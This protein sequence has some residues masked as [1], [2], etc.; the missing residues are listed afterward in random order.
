DV[1]AETIVALARRMASN[2]TMI[3]ASW[4]LQRA[5]HGEQP[6]W[7]TVAL[8]AMLGQIGL[9]GGGFALGHG[10]VNAAGA[11]AHAF[12]GPVLPQGINADKTPIPVARIADMP[13]DPGGE[14]QFAGQACTLPDIRLIY[15]CGGNPFHHHQDLNR[16]IAAWRKPETIVIHEQFWTAAA[17]HADIVLP[18]TTSLERDDIGS[19]GRDRFM[20]AMKKAVDAPGE[21]RDDYAIFA[22]ISERLG[23][24]RAYTENRDTMQW[25]RYLYEASRERADRYGIEL[26]G[27]DAFWAQGY[28]EV[29]K[30]AEPHVMF[31]DFRAD[32]AAHRLPTPS[33]KIEIFSERIAAFGYADCPGHPAWF[34]PVEWLGAANRR[35]PLHLISSQPATKLHSQYDHGVVSVERKIRGR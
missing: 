19:T 7:L 15:W 1:P 27:F 11:D 31:R 9:P 25:L 30:P 3:S 33:G 26:P 5:D 2:R 20:I 17:K 23:T 18:A 22:A 4:S 8:A 6:F 34:E 35:Y 10:P 16:L 24:Q 13:L 32:P 21:A 14:Y 29:P 12:S 28:F